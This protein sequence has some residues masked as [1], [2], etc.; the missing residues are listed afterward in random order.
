MTQKVLNKGILGQLALSA[1][2]EERYHELE[3]LSYRWERW[4]IKH[5]EGIF[6]LFLAPCKDNCPTVASVF[7]V[8]QLT[9]I[10]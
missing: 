4:W 3:H 7:W 8:K 6:S 9:P 5:E 1:I 2:G 10:K